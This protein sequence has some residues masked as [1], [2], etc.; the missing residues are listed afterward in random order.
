MPQFVLANSLVGMLHGQAVVKACESASRFI[1]QATVQQPCFGAAD[2]Y[3]QLVA[4]MV[5]ITIVPVSLLSC[6]RRGDHCCF[7]WACAWRTGWDRPRHRSHPP[8]T[9]SMMIS[10]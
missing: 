2:I 6:P 1:Y 9:F 7:E 5:P 10:K 8:A 4:A 3:R